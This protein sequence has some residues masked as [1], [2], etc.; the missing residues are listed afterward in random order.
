[1]LNLLTECNLSDLFL[2]V[3]ISLIESNFAR[4]ID[5]D[6]GTVI[7]KAYKKFGTKKVREA[8]LLS[9]VTKPIIFFKS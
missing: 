9:T 6:T 7:T 3:C 1:M 2:K 8:T 4:I 5:F